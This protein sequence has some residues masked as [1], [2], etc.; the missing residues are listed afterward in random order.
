MHGY[1]CIYTMYFTQERYSVPTLKCF[2]IKNALLMSK[3][4][5]KE[6][7]ERQRN[8]DDLGIIVMSAFMTSKSK[9]WL[10]VLL[11]WLY[12]ILN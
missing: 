11:K 3:K 1:S 4:I 10:N 8:V 2:K 9:V 7:F 5:L 12:N 6:S